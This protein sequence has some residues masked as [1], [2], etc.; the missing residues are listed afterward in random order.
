MEDDVQRYD[1]STFF[2]LRKRPGT[3][4]GCS[5]TALQ[6]VL[7]HP[8]F[9]DDRDSRPNRI[10]QQQSSFGRSRPRLTTSATVATST[11]SG[12]RDVA[13]VAV[14]TVAEVAATV[15]A[16]DKLA[17]KKFMSA[18]NK[19]NK[20][21]MFNLLPEIKNT[22]KAMDPLSMTWV[23]LLLQQMYKQYPYIRCYSFILSSLYFQCGPASR[24]AFARVYEQH[25]RSALATFESN[26]R[27]GQYAIRD[28]DVK[29][30]YDMFCD[31]NKKKSQA[32]SQMASFVILQTEYSNA[33]LDEADATMPSLDIKAALTTLRNL[34]S[35]SEYIDIVVDVITEWTENLIV[36]PSNAEKLR[37]HGLVHSLVEELLMQVSTE[38]HSMRVICVLKNVLEKLTTRA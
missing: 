38:T 32:I 8:C 29:E 4:S 13:E 37:V 26:V 33:A 2:S 34:S 14:A 11:S 21:N 25:Y 35:S 28:M 5:R 27:E 12:T 31:M 15:A 36:S 19:L 9:R 16:D 18:M 6:S 17:M 22:V 1:L 30:N 7:N 24:V 3:L 23:A 10:K 20:N